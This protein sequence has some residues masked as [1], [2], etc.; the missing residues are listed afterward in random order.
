MAK[1]RI[2]SR[3][4]IE[5]MRRSGKAASILLQRIGEAVK[6]G[7]STYELDQVSRETIKELGGISSFLG[8]QLPEHEP[9]PATICA[10]INEEV[11]HGIPSRNRI[12]KKG[13]IIGIDTA[14][15]L[16]GYH[17]DNAFTFCVGEISPDAQKLL[18]VTRG[19]LYRAIDAAKPG[20]RLGDV[21]YATQNYAETHGCSVARDFVGHGIG[22][23]MHEAPQVANFGEPGKGVRLKP[24][25]VLAIEPMINAGTHEA[26]VRENGWTAA[27]ADGSLSAHFEHTVAI[28]S[29]GPEIL[30]YNSELWGD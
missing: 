14:I 23:K 30:T 28:L 11:I 7:A 15:F 1:I 10:S 6:P 12:L 21:C 22:R 8:Y 26:V 17:G 20:N 29:D 3:S 25:M 19:A 16:G 4:E 13:D 9:Y 24:G 5:A 27:T 2:K 18:D